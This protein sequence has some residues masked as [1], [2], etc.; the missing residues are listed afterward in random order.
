MWVGGPGGASLQECK[1]AKFLSAL[2]MTMKTHWSKWLAA[3]ILAP[4]FFVLLSFQNCAPV[5]FQSALPEQTKASQSGEADGEGGSQGQVQPEQ[6]VPS[7]ELPPAETV[8]IPPAPTP[9]PPKPCVD[10]KGVSRDDGATW[11]VE[12]ES[13]NQIMCPDSDTLS[14]TMLTTESFLCKDGVISLVSSN[15]MPKT[16]AP[17]CPAPTLSVAA[18]PMM[19]PV[20]TI[21]NLVISSR[22]VSSVSYTCKE[23]G[24]A[25]DLAAGTVQPGNSQVPVLVNAD[26]TCI[27]VA[28]NSA[29]TKLESSVTIPVECGNKIKNGGKCEDFSCKEFRTVT[30]EN[31]LLEVPARSAAGICYTVKLMDAIAA[32]ARR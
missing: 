4:G 21:A 29:G 25:S 15:T 19:A 22:Y 9:V 13:Q 20:G 30:I 12:T 23:T 31:G 28:T 16:A 18:N 1:V 24:R 6:T 7:L 27:V 3:A 17:E 26:V 14:Q 32:S 5:N 10:D 11:L 8:F 2:K